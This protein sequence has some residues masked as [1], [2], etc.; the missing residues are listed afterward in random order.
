MQD[1]ALHSSKQQDTLTTLRGD[2]PASG[3]CKKGLIPQ[4][5]EMESKDAA[6]KDSAGAKKKNLTFLRHRLYMLE[7]RKTDTV[8]E[9]TILGDH[10]SSGTL[11]R[12]QSDRSEYS[13]KL[14]GKGGMKQGAL[15]NGNILKAVS[16]GKNMHGGLQVVCMWGV[17][18]SLIHNCGEGRGE[19]ESLC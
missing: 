2:I 8:V 6:G 19:R 7:R 15:L 1:A 17:F 12:S 18:Q 3:V 11:R 14:Q 9:N 16:R 13:Q 5:L 4:R 10:N